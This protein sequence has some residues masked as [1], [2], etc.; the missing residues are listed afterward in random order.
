MTLSEAL[1]NYSEMTMGD[2]GRRSYGSGTS[3]QEQKRLDQ[4]KR[5]EWL[6]SLR[7]GPPGRRVRS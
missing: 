5:A 6:A 3:R 2:D 4:K 1:A 7:R